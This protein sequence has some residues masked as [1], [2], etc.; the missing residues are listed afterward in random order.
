MEEAFIFYTNF[1][2]ARN[3]YILITFEN[4]KNGFFL[5]IEKKI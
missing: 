1:P 4:S 3:K 5:D 2:K